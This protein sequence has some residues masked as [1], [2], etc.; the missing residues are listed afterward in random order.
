MGIFLFSVSSLG[1]NNGLQTASEGGTT[2]ADVPGVHGGPLLINRGL[3]GHD[4][5]VADGAG[6]LLH[7]RPEGKVEW[8]CIW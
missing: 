5:W 8:V 7:M 1:G 6:P 4:V 3:Q 2:A